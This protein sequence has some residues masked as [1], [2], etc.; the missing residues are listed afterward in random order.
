M[1]LSTV[2]FLKNK[3]EIPLRA[4]GKKKKKK[5]C[6]GSQIE[7]TLGFLHGVGLY[8]VQMLPWSRASFYS[9]TPLPTSTNSSMFGPPESWRDSA[10]KEEGT[11]HRNQ[12]RR[13]GAPGLRARSCLSSLQAP[14]CWGHRGAHPG[15]PPQAL[16]PGQCQGPHGQGSYATRSPPP[17]RRKEVLMSAL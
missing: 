4:F 14:P 11:N 10:R 7:T 8:E 15:T 12:K 5:V 9:H 1:G 2:T 6:Q 3:Q 16:L 13:N 17:S